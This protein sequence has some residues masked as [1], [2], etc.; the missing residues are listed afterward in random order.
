IILAVLSVIQ[1]ASAIIPGG[2]GGDLGGSTGIEYGMGAPSLLLWPIRPTEMKL[3]PSGVNKEM[4]VGMS[5]EV[6]VTGTPRGLY[7]MVEYSAGQGGFQAAVK[8]N[9][10]G[11]DGK[12]NPADVIMNVQPV[13]AGIQDRYTRM[14]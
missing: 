2:F 3:R 1:Y 7:R 4:P 10:P 8:T 9:E 12:E 11:V 5:E 14:S 13:P 6:T